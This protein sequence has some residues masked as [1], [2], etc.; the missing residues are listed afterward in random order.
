M[1]I[2]ESLRHIILENV[3]LQQLKEKYVGEKK[4]VSEEVFT[5]IEQVCKN[6]FYLVQWLTKKVGTFV[7]KSEDIYKFEEYFEIFEKHKNRFEYK[8]INQYKTQEDVSNFI[9][10]C[11]EIREKNIEFEDIPKSNNY[12]SQNEIEKLESSGGA[13]FVGMFDGYQVFRIYSP[14]ESTWKIYRDLLGRCKG[15]DSGAKIEICTI[16]NYGYF[17][18]YLEEYRLSN[19]FVLYNLEDS[20]S[21]Y[22]LHIESGQFMDKNDDEDIK[23]NKTNFYDWLSERVKEYSKNKI[24]RRLKKSGSILPVR[25]KGYEDEKGKQGWWIQYSSSGNINFKAQFKD[26]KINGKFLDYLYG[27]SD[28]QKVD[29]VTTYVDGEKNGPYEE[30][31]EKG[32]IIR[33][34]HYKN[35]EEVGIWTM[36]TFS[37]Y[38]TKDF[39]QTPVMTSYLT[40]RKKLIRQV[41]GEPRGKNTTITYHP[42]GKIKSKGNFSSQGR[43]GKW[44]FYDEKGELFATGHYSRGKKTGKWEIKWK[45]ETTRAGKT[46]TKDVV[47]KAEVTGRSPS[48]LEKYTPDG[49]L[50]FKGSVFGDSKKEDYFYDKIWTGG[51]FH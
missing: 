29:S 21:P 46:Y 19:Y 37:G 7:I 8:D 42:N 34:G 22:Q 16:S 39:D 12:L 28:E 51:L 23:I 3:L 13:K 10:T 18:R 20:K 17:K 30:Y 44:L 32:K 43:T 41:F 27:I 1:K 11:I 36:R 9:R 15:R 4:P 45:E 26:D 31:D 6:K 47:Y 33:T 24:T 25:G 50:L 48:T 35:N 5:E 2:F 14:D 40:K 49:K 38:E